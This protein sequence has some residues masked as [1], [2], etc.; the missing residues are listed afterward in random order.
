MARWQNEKK[1]SKLR[2][3]LVPSQLPV[4][5]AASHFW[6]RF[7]FSVPRPA[8][9]ARLPSAC[10]VLAAFGR[11]LISCPSLV[12]DDRQCLHTRHLC[13]IPHLRHSL[14]D[15]QHRSSC[16]LAPFKQLFY[17]PDWLRASA[18]RVVLR[19]SIQLLST[20]HQYGDRSRPQGH[21]SLCVSLRG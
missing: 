12:L 14:V 7:G 21:L 5:A 16:L 11:V 10:I 8:P 6:L 19:P 15:S 4:P 20:T 17:P 2:C 18:H 13:N 3:S 1:Y 9:Q